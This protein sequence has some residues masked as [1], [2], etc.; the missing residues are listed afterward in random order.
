MDVR[1]DG[2]ADHPQV[3]GFQSER[4][5]WIVSRKEMVEDRL[6]IT[7]TPLSLS[8]FPS[9][10]PSTWRF[11][12]WRNGCTDSVAEIRFEDPFSSGINVTGR[13]SW[14]WNFRPVGSWTF[15]YFK[16]GGREDY[17]GHTDRGRREGGE[18]EVTRPSFV[19]RIRAS[20]L[21]GN[22]RVPQQSDNG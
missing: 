2:R 7:S 10:S 1:F 12:P 4:P 13:C 14:R 18:G 5:V 22:I 6:S 9:L 20:V 17:G 19:F 15:V 16:P 3:S 21:A 11:L 8:P